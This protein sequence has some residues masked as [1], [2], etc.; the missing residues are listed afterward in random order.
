[1]PDG[2]RYA[3]IP[4]IYDQAVG[5]EIQRQIDES[6]LTAQSVVGRAIA[7]SKVPLLV[8]EALAGVGSR[9]L[10]ACSQ[11]ESELFKGE[12]CGREDSL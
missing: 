10:D 12:A 1:M 5:V 9:L 11:T 6:G 7:F 8:L 2:N 4:P 3:Q